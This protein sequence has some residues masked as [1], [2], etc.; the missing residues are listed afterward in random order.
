[1]ISERIASFGQA[2]GG[3][4]ARLRQRRSDRGAPGT[5]I[6]ESRLWGDLEARMPGAPQQGRSPFWDAPAHWRT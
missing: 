1:M 5:T 2:V 6:L 3:R 4:A